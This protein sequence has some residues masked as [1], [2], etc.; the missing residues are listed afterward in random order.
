MR[1][2]DPLQGLKMGQLHFITHI[3]FFMVMILMIDIEAAKPD[4]KE[5]NVEEIDQFELRVNAFETLKWGHLLMAIFQV[6]CMVL[7]HY[8]NQNMA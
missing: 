7:K 6:G 2:K 3:S 4:D 1:L 8:G 5:E